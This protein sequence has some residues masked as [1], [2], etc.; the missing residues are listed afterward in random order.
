MSCRLGA[1]KETTLSLTG[2]KMI[3]RLIIDCKVISCAT[4]PLWENISRAALASTDTTA[5]SPHQQ[6]QQNIHPQPEHQQVEESLVTGYAPVGQKRVEVQNLTIAKGL[7]L[8]RL[9]TA[10]VNSGGNSKTPA[11]QQQNLS[12]RSVFIIFHI[13]ILRLSPW[14][15]NRQIVARQP[16]PREKKSSG[17]SA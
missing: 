9:N 4:F 13:N 17:A 12:A 14:C 2:E 1:Q 16:T 3:I 15:R 5:P 11:E 8:K 6:P 10:A 7:R